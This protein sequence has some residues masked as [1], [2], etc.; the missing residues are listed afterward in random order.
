MACNDAT[1]KSEAVSSTRRAAA[2]TG[3]GPFLGDVI[4]AN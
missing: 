4:P 1:D 3:A 2:R